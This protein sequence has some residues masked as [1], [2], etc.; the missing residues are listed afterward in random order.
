MALVGAMDIVG[1][2]MDVLGTTETTTVG[3]IPP[4]G[5]TIISSATAVLEATD[6]LRILGVGAGIK[7]NDIM[8]SVSHPNMMS[9]VSKAGTDSTVEPDPM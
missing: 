2:E 7:T 1:L 6:H 4:G 5:M 9:S 8:T 3:E